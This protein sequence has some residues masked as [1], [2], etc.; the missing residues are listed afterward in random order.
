MVLTGLLFVAVTGIVKYLGSDLPSVEAAF[1][2]YLFGLMFFVP[3]LLRLR[4]HALRGRVLGLTDTETPAAI[5]A[6]LSVFC[7]LVLL[8]PA[9]MES[10]LV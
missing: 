8:P 10:C 4:L 9:L 3:F 7:T 2:R 6:M 1:I 5:V